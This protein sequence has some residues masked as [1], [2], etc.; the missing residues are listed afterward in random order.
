MCYLQMLL[1]MLKEGLSPGSTSRAPAASHG[2]H[3]CQLPVPWLS[4]GQG[5]HRPLW[6]MLAKWK[7]SLNRTAVNPA[8]PMQWNLYLGL[9]SE[10]LMVSE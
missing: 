2:S 8:G 7:R 6:V 1:A 5:C 9:F 10:H 3:S 4:L